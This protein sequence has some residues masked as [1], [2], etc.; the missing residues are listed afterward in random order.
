MSLRREELFD[1]S[2][3]PLALVDLQRR[4]PELR[5]RLRRLLRRY[6]WEP[7]AGS[8]ERHLQSETRRTLEALGYL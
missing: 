2:D 8:V 5:D 4:A 3:D 7:I 1:L 6:R